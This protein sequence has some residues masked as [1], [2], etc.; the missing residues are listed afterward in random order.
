MPAPARH[1]LAIVLLCDGGLERWLAEARARGLITA[2]GGPGPAVWVEG[3]FASASV[4]R[5]AERFVSSGQGGFRV[6]S[7]S[8]QNV[9]AAFVGALTAWRAGGPRHLEI[10]G[11]RVDLRSLTFR[12]PCGFGCESLTLHDVGSATLSWVPEGV[13]VV[14]V[15]G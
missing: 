2:E 7:A 14:C 1:S 4:W 13:A 5:G 6:F 11:Q 3:G 8:E 12:P 10:E 9:T 15:R